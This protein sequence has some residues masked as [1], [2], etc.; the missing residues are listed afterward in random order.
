M[1]RLRPVALFIT[2]ASLVVSVVTATT[3]FKKRALSTGGVGSAEEW[4]VGSPAVLAPQSFVPDGLPVLLSDINTVTENHGDNKHAY[5]SSLQFRAVTPGGEEITSVSLT[6][7][8]FDSGGKLR[9]VDGWI[10]PVD[11]SSG[12][13]ADITLPLERRLQNGNRLLLGVECANGPSGRWETDSA[14]LAM[15]VAAATRGLPL[16]NTIVKEE[17]P[18][19]DDS[20]ASLCANGYRHALALARAGDGSGV[21]S[22]TCNQHERSYQFTFNGKVLVR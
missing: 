4:R 21:T 5:V 3:I 6:V 17:Q 11:L 7:F 14:D 12:K 22:Y 18:A 2:I 1:S 10:K 8:E 15:S 16:V 9:R 13:T 19:Q 20:G